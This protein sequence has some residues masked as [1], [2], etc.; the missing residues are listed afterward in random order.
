[1]TK[2][3]PPLIDKKI[4]SSLKNI[5]FFLIRKEICFLNKKKVFSL[6][7]KSN[8]LGT[9]CSESLPPRVPGL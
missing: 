6:S 2:T 4:L 5:L 9:D 7:S 1:M 8:R 3:I